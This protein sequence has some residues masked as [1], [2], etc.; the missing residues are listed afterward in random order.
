MYGV[1][2]AAQDDEMS[3][4][5]GGAESA[6]STFNCRRRRIRSANPFGVLLKLILLRRASPGQIHRV[7]GNGAKGLSPSRKVLPTMPKTT[8]PAGDIY[9]AVPAPD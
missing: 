6:V 7:G 2:L 4:N 9:K 5:Y 1:G 3:T 8:V